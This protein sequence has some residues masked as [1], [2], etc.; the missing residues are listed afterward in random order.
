LVSDLTGK[1]IPHEVQLLMQ[2]GDRFNMPITNHQNTIFEYIKCLENGIEKLRKT[3]RTNIRNKSVK[4]LENLERS[5]KIDNIDNL[6]YKWHNITKDFIKNNKNIIF[7]KADKSNMTVAIDKLQ[8]ENIHL[9]SD[10]ENRSH[11]L[12]IYFLCVPFLH[13]QFIT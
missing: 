11:V 2:L 9:N 5:I 8:Y 7:T 4:V 13:C 3:D 10:G 6:L 1:V 12:L